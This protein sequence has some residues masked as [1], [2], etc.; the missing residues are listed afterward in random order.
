MVTL[1]Y[2]RVFLGEYCVVFV[3]AL[4]TFSQD[5][6]WV[7]YRS[8]CKQM[9]IRLTW[10]N[11]IK[12]SISILIYTFLKY[13]NPSITKNIFLK[14][15]PQMFWFF[16]NIFIQHPS[17]CLMLH[18]V[19]RYRQFASCCIYQMKTIWHIVTKCLDWSNTNPNRL[20]Q[21]KTWKLCW[22]LFKRV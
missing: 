17:K 22:F 13:Y 10:I 4:L 18:E 21:F 15:V 2:V 7:S 8:E 9:S 12:K 1:I 3:R 19:T 20:S 6:V 14:M 16:L 11:W 5:S